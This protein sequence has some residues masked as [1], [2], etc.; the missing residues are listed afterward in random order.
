MKVAALREF[1]VSEWRSVRRDPLLGG[2]LVMV[3]LFGLATRW[4]V[5]GIASQFG[6]D[7]VVATGSKAARKIHSRP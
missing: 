2:V 7:L 1:A 6:I 3:L 4:L 5:P